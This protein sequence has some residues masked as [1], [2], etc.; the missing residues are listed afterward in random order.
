MRFLLGR[1]AAVGLLLAAAGAGSPAATQHDVSDAG[2]EVYLRTCASCHGD[3]ATGYGPA[4]WVLATRPPDLTAFS[5][6]TT[7][8]PRERLRNVITGRIRPVPSHGGNEMPIWRTALD[9][10]VS[11]PGVTGLEALLTYL[12]D[13]QRQKFGPYQGPSFETLA[14]AGE[15]LYETHCATCHSEDGRGPAVQPGYRVGVSMDLTTIASRNA[16]SFELRQVY[17][18]IARCDR[19]ARSDMP[20]WSEGLQRAGWGE[21]L[22]MKNI[23][24]L[25]TYVESIQR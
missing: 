7:P 17:E 3:A 12:D 22:T 19:K 25:A 9:A 24:A 23:E 21:Y 14:S 13:L 16:G 5:N 1:L 11:T 20:N 15:L 2:R 18:S 8:F 6:R 4:S 10:V